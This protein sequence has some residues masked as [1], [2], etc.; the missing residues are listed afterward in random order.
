MPL[1]IGDVQ[2]KSI[3]VAVFVT[4][5]KFV[6][7]LGGPPIINV[8]IGPNPTELLARNVTVYLALAD[9]PVSFVV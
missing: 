5:L 6:T 4:V 3:V 1:L 7:T 9:K 2:L 8:D